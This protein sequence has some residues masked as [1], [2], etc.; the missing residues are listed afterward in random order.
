[1]TFCDPLLQPDKKLW[2]LLRPPRAEVFLPC[3]F[4]ARHLQIALDMLAP[5]SSPQTKNP[6]SS[7]AQSFLTGCGA[8]LEKLG[9]SGGV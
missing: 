6:L 2:I 3:G 1:M 4:V 9:L 7:N 5:R 8:V